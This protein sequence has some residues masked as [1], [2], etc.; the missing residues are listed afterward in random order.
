MLVIMGD[1]LGVSVGDLFTGAV[2]PGVV[3]FIILQLIGLGL[4]F[5]FPSRVTGLPAMAYGR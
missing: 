5:A 3:P 2:F 4:V 1:Q